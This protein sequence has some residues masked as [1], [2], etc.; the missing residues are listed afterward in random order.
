[1]NP[2]HYSDSPGGKP[3]VSVITGYY[4]RSDAVEATIRSILDQTF[5]DLELIAF[6]DCSNDGTGECLLRLQAELGDSRFRV[7]I[8]E[9]NRG[10]TQGMIDAI[11]ASQADYICIQGSGDV[12]LP[13]RIARQ[14]QLLDSRPE[15][16]AV[17]CWYTNIVSTTGA[18][19]ERRPNADDVAL[20]DLLEENVFSHGEVMMRRETYL[21]AGG[22]RVAFKYSQDIDLWLRIVR[23]ARLATVPEFLYERY[24]R[25]DGVSYEPRKFSLQA[26]YSILARR[27][28]VMPPADAQDALQRLAAHGPSTMIPDNDP[29]LQKR[30]IKGALR[31]AIFDASTNAEEVV[32][33]NVTGAALR[34]GLVAFIRLL[35][36][37]LMSP[38]RTLTARMLGIKARGA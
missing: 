34:F 4:N 5:R 32:R 9:T 8:H 25:F 17:G 14:V 22:Y 2:A 31:S 12:S 3:K 21:R 20:E 19:R 35:R 13:E 10:F 1:M 30:Y 28:A 26:R 24:V 38:A 16:G 23:L 6:D 11:A 36:S 7:I 29:D 15:V 33:S 18:R 37:P 27:F